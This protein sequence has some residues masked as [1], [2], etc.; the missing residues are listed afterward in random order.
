MDERTRPEW[1]NEVLTVEEAQRYLKVGR[2][3][4]YELTKSGEIP[5]FKIGP[6]SAGTK[7]QSR[8]LIRLEDLREYVRRQ[9]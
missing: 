9:V 8:T 5:C 4:M 7:K 6:K 1:E 3:T 2:T